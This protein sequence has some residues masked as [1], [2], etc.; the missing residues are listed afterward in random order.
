MN[1]IVAIHLSSKTSALQRLIES[2]SDEDKAKTL[3]VETPLKSVNGR[4]FHMNCRHIKVPLIIPSQQPLITIP[5]FGVDELDLK[6]KEYNDV[7]EDYNKNLDTEIK[8]V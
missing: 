8:F 7:V 5:F 4:Q 6:I 1:N 3:V 2:M